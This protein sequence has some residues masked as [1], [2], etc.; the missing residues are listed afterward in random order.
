[1]RVWRRL[2]CERRGCFIPRRARRARH[3]GAGP[4]QDVQ[5]ARQRGRTT[6][7]ARPA[8]SSVRG[9]VVLFHT[10]FYSKQIR[11]PR[12][13]NTA[14]AAPCAK[15]TSPFCG[16]LCS[17]SA[18][19]VKRALVCSVKQLVCANFA[20]RALVCSAGASFA[21]RSFVLS[22]SDN[23]N[24]RAADDARARASASPAPPASMPHGASGSLLRRHI[25]RLCVLASALRCACMAS[26]SS[27]SSPNTACHSIGVTALLARVSRSDKEREKRRPG[28]AHFA[29][30]Y[31]TARPT[32]LARQ[33]I[34]GT[35][36]H[37][38][39]VHTCDDSRAFCARVPF[40]FFVVN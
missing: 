17:A 32:E 5:G 4:L 9:G 22:A 35:N 8:G 24:K 7:P 11:K 36:R 21:K 39:T 10:H 40:S 15:P 16:K 25:W 34:V 2:K 26:C 6:R 33:K 38:C 18:N 12:V 31:C 23:F 20:K 30:I 19:C 13:C 29:D 14:K 1:M 3:L 28:R 37:P 27:S